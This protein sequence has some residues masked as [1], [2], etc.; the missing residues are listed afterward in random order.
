VLTP[1]VIHR[2]GVDRWGLYAL[3]VTITGFLSSFDGGLGAST[4]RYF[5]IYAGKDDRVRTT[6]LMVTL[7]LMIAG[8]TAIFV[9]LCWL[10]APHLIGLF[11][12]PASLDAEGA[13]LLRALV[14]L[15]G[16]SFIHN[17]FQ[18]LLY[19]RRRYAFVNLTQTACNG[20]WA[21]GLFLA[22][23]TGGN[24]RQMAWVFIAQQALAIA[25]MIPAGTRYLTS[26]DFRL[27]SWPELKSFLGF[28]SRVQ[29]TSL[30][31]LLN[32]QMDAL[33]IATVLPIRTV[34]FYNTGSNFAYQLRSVASNGLGPANNVLGNEFGAHGT[35]R[36]QQEF[37]RVLRLWVVV[38]CGWTTAGIGA[39]Y[40]G[41]VAWLG[42]Q[43]R[44]AGQI[45]VL[46]TA[47]YAFTLFTGMYQLYAGVLGRPGL[48]S[49]SAVVTVAVNAVLT[50]PLVFVGPLGVV[51]ATAVSA[52][53]G[54]LYLQRTLHRKLDADM[55][56][57]AE[58]VPILPVGICLAVTVA[59]ELFVRPYIVSG[60]LGL[61]SCA[62]PALV[63]VAVYGLAVLGPRRAVYEVWSRVN[64]RVSAEGRLL[65]PS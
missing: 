63:G 51:A 21:V 53:T 40:F 60:A 50:V 39:A 42:P 11:N 13:Y 38:V 12:V 34:A 45:A 30:A 26:R 3:T 31:T 19:A 47:G 25:M 8:F 44:L 65:D 22:V 2:L 5:S 49:R 7:V 28:S 43:F 57:F 36:M 61:L 48:V 20:V 41:I 32:S 1:F 29:L 9:S 6:R 35:A 62:L 23:D 10:L 58:F 64:R 24:L 16:A 46:L 27:M 4:Q 17:L 18:G 56:T 15:V 37:R 14:V 33:V 52:L 55:P 54:C 59:L